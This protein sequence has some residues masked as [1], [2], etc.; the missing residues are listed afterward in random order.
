VST[1]ERRILTMIL[2]PVLGLVVVAA[3]LMWEKYEAWRRVAGLP[4]FLERFE[5]AERVAETLAVEGRE[6]IAW[7]SGGGKD[8]RG[9]VDAAR[10]RVDALDLAGLGSE[11][12]EL[13]NRISALAMVRGEIDM[14]QIARPEVEK[15]YFDAVAGL[16]RAVDRRTLDLPDPA[17]RRELSALALLAELQNQLFREEAFGLALLRNGTFDPEAYDRY[18]RAISRGRTALREVREDLPEALRSRLDSLTADPATAELESWRAVLEATART[19][20]TEGRDPRGY[21]ERVEAFRQRLRDIVTELDARARARAE[22]VARGSLMLTVGLGG[23]LL[24]LFALATAVM[25]QG[26]REIRRM[27]RAEEEARAEA[28][29][30]RR[31]LA[32]E[33]AGRFEREVGSLVEGVSA[34]VRDLDRAAEA[35]REDAG[36]S[37][38]EGDEAARFVQ[39]ISAHVQ[40]VAAAAEQLSQSSR[41]VASQ[42]ARASEMSREIGDKARETGTVMRRLEETAA[43][44]GAIVR[45]IADIAEQTH[46]LALNATIEAA[47]AGEAGRGFTVVASEV[48]N[49]ARQTA[50]ATEEIDARIRAVQ[51]AAGDAVASG[52][53]IREAI[54]ELERIAAAI[55]A[56]AEQQSATVAEVARSAQEGASGVE[57]VDRRVGHIRGALETTGERAEA[58]HR[59]T[60]R[61][62]RAAAELAERVRQFGTEVRQVA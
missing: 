47:R 16:A 19:F 56:A 5:A 25:L 14:G 21:L 49:L 20:S 22:G 15:S 7:L 1:L 29:R 18:I 41:E 54:G 45:T 61:C 13:I 57:D 36:R 11:F 51:E 34:L 12:R 6:S 58:M 46:L 9:P 35:M 2:L 55:A 40:A 59:T 27:R 33:I 26:F 30:E 8:W 17:L 48:K 62:T 24:L 4:D 38:A 52:S 37:R 42:I 3:W 10:Q 23:G 53:H 44:I 60:E 43:D 28:E 32:E 50:Q 39:Q 31:R